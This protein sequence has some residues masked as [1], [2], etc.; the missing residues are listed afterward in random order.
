MADSV[1]T[2]IE[3]AERLLA[4]ATL[5]AENGCYRTAI[6]LAVLSMEESGKACLVLW[7]KAGHLATSEATELKLGHI[8]K[9]RIFGTYRTLKAINAVGKVVPKAELSLAAYGRCSTSTLGFKRELSK[10]LRKHAF[11]PNAQAELGLLDHFKQAGFYVDIDEKL[12]VVSPAVEYN[13][14]WFNMVAD[15]AKESLEMVR[16]DANEH[17]IM[18]VL[19]SAQTGKLPSRKERRAFLDDFARHVQKHL[20]VKKDE[21]S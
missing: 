11:V 20:T 19:Y 13:E 17:K 9:Q 12:E 2:I 1:A 4:E 3:N 10:A 15:D 6:S 16:S 21:L 7:I 5:L 8:N 14:D 18:A